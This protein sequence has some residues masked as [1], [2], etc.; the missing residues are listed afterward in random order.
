MINPT[1]GLPQGS[2]LAPLLFAIYINDVL[3]EMN[4]ELEDCETRGFADDT[5]VQT[6]TLRKLQSE[7]DRLVDALG[8]LGL[9][10]NPQK[11]V[12]RSDDGAN[13]IY[14]PTKFV[15]FSQP[16]A[17][18]LRQDVTR[19]GTQTSQREFFLGTYRCT[20]EIQ[21]PEPILEDKDV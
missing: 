18:Y 3:E 12:L 8:G 11:T 6:M 15:I 21:N 1:Q 17:K 13:I 19:E 2:A 9:R 16:L 7:F 5:L 14:E 4:T 20:S 10:V